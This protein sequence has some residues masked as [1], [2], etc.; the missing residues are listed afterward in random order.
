AGYADTA[1]LK[2]IDDQ[3]IKVVVPSQR[4]A[5]HKKEDK[6]FSKNH[7]RYDKEKDCYFCP[8]QNVLT[9]EFT[10]SKRGKKY[11]RITEPRLCRGC[12]HFGKCTKNK[13]GRRIMRLVHEYQKKKFEALYK[14]TKEIN[15]QRKARAE[16]P[17]GALKRILKPDG[18]WLRGQGGFRGETPLRASCFDLR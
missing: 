11:Y 7:F 5:L 14:T 3:A 9:Y 15:A 8:E 17:F 12:V 1:E 13:N 4:Q 2:K 16:L 18:S 10:D 6:P